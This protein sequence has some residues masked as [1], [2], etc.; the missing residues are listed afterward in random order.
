MVLLI[1]CIGKSSSTV[2]NTLM[3]CKSLHAPE[4]TFRHQTLRHDKVQ[5]DTY[6]Y[7]HKMAKW[8]MLKK[9]YCWFKTILDQV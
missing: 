5:L 9:M 7:G 2:L 3:Q 1:C 8:C 6:L 4:E